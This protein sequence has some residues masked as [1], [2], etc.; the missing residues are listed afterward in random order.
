MAQN[1]QSDGNGSN[2]ANSYAKYMGIAFQM[3]VIIGICTFAGYKIDEAANHQTKWV[4][5]LLALLGVFGSL[6]LVIRSVK[7]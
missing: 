5:A 1:E 3:L 2:E 4:T 7:N 6:F